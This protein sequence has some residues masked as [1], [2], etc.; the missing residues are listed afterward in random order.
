MPVEYRVQVLQPAA[1]VF[2]GRWSPAGSKHLHKQH[3]F[4]LVLTDSGEKR[5]ISL[6]WKLRRNLQEL[7]PAA[8]LLT[9]D[10]QIWN[11]NLLKNLKSFILKSQIPCPE[12]K[13]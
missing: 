11:L 9:S 6:L 7:T 4:W 12:S 10:G 8:S 3:L 5:Y 13:S 2:S 1:V